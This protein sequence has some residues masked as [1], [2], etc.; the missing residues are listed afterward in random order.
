MFVR[1]SVCLFAVVSVTVSILPLTDGYVLQRMRECAQARDET[2][3]FTDD[4][5]PVRTSPPPRHTDAG[6]GRFVFISRSV[7]RS[8][9]SNK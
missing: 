2:D 6:G 5:S 1:L 3:R 7:A 8:R 4:P 9:T